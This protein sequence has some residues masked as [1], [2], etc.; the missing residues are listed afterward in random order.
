MAPKASEERE[1]SDFKI[2]LKEV[3]SKVQLLFNMLVTGHNSLTGIFVPYL[4]L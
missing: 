3:P 2:P 4:S 1:N